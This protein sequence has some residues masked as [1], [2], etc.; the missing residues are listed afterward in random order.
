VISCFVATKVICEAQHVKNV[1]VT[2]AL[3]QPP[4]PTNWA[5]SDAPCLLV[6]HVWRHCFTLPTPPQPPS[7]SLLA[8]YS[9]PNT[10]PIDRFSKFCYQ[11]TQRRLCN[12]MIIKEPVA[13]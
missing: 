4:P 10:P 13:P 7:V 12:K 8:L 5:A 3:P 9:R 11:Q 6:S 2:S 1:F